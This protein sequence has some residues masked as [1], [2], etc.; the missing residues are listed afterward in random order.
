VEGIRRTQNSSSGC[1]SRKEI[2]CEGH[3]G[4]ESND[5]ERSTVVLA[6]GFNRQQRMDDGLMGDGIRGE[7][8]F[9]LDLR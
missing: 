2:F 9:G 3:C 1:E 5:Q 4:S 8:G 6:D 7:Q